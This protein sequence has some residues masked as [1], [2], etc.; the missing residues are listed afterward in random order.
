MATDVSCLWGGRRIE[1]KDVVWSFF[2][3]IDKAKKALQVVHIYWERNCLKNSGQTS[4]QII[5]WY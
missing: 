4:R 2:P 3:I 1:K 5:I